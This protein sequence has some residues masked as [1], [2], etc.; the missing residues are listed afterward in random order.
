MDAISILKRVSL[1]TLLLAGSATCASAAGPTCP[2]KWYTPKKGLAEAKASN[3]PVVMVFSQSGT[4]SHDWFAASYKTKEGRLVWRHVA[5]L[6]EAKVVLIKVRP[7]ARLKLTADASAQQVS[8]LQRANKKLLERYRKLTARYA[9]ARIP[10]VLFLSPNGDTVF[11]TYTR[12]PESTVVSALK[13]MPQYFHHY[14]QAR[15]LMEKTDPAKVKTDVPFGPTEARGNW[16]SSMSHAIAAAKAKDKPIVAVFT[17]TGSTGLDWFGHIPGLYGDLE[18]SNNKELKDSG[19][20]LAKIAPPTKLKLAV[21]TP[22]T[23][24]G[25]LRT[26]LKKMTDNYAKW[27][28]KYGVTRIPSVRFLSPDGQMVLKSYNRQPQSLVITGLKKMGKLFADYKQM[29]EMLKE[30]DDD[31]EDKDDKIESGNGGK[32]NPKNSGGDF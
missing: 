28:K 6:N 22:Y 2:L 27:A 14:Q 7:P 10:T 32:V 30:A 21:G 20:V 24:V 12:V 19:A 8:M 17:Q 1:A 13:H 31:E 23:E 29:R 26:A 4:R 15:A 16:Y 5:A 11:K 9:I 18:W 25:K 3:R